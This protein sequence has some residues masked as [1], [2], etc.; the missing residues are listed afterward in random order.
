ME[1]TIIKKVSNV[2]F[3]D[4][5]KRAQDFAI[6]FVKSW[7]TLEAYNQAFEDVQKV[8]ASYMLQDP[9]VW[10]LIFTNL[11]KKDKRTQWENEIITEYDRIVETFDLSPFELYLIFADK[12]KNDQCIAV[13]LNIDCLESYKV[14][15]Y[16][17]HF[18]TLLK[19]KIFYRTVKDRLQDEA[20]MI[21]ALG[22]K[23]EKDAMLRTLSKI[24]DIDDME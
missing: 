6:K 8:R 21:K 10:E 20:N 1:V 16:L 19:R 2:Y 22:K 23:S 5:D 9:A 14:L 4:T 3:H 18:F 13:S 17:Y 7:N 12:G 24:I 11:R 15:T